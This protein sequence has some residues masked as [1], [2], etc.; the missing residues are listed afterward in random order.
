MSHVPFRTTRQAALVHL[1]LLPLAVLA[2]Q[3]FPVPRELPPSATTQLARSLDD[4]KTH[5]THVWRD[6]RA[7]N[8][9]ETVNA[10]IEIS[11]GDR[12]KWEFAMATNARAVDRIMPEHIGGYPVNYG[13][14][15]QTISYDGDPFDALVLG[16]PISGGRVV[17][18]GIVGLMLMEDEKG[19]DAKVVLS[20]TGPQATP[21]HTLTERERQDIAS[22]FRRY[23]QH[24]P[25]K[26]S[27]VPGWG[28]IADGMAHVRTTHAFFRECRESAGAPCRLPG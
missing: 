6:T 3:P 11:R 27:T 20:V 24:E 9:D 13:F 23:K 18:G 16:P 21:R 10:Y 28:S 5:A 1:A 4:S 22:Y 17:R 19:W 15:P 2:R 26:S 25:G 8:D 14:V 7:F 12:R